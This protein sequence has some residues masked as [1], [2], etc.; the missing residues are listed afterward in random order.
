M[1][2]FLT[3]V[4][5]STEPTLK[6]IADLKDKLHRRNLQIKDLKAEVFKLRSLPLVRDTKNGIKNTPCYNCNKENCQ[7]CKLS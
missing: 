2:K 3:D 7:D 6:E 1:D 5:Y 4:I